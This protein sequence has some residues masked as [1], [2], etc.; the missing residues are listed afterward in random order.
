[1]NDFSQA[2][3]L[4]LANVKS[5]GHLSFQLEEDNDKTIQHPE[6]FVKKAYDHILENNLAQS[7][8]NEKIVSS[9]LRQLSHLTEK[10]EQELE[11]LNA[12]FSKIS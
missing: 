8:N 2:L 6:N 3:R 9:P 5:N 10:G 4:L 12:A 11:K 7:E 1:M